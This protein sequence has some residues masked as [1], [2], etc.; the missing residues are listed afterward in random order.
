MS[1][2]LAAP[3]TDQ[4]SPAIVTD[5]LV[6][7]YGEIVALDGVSLTVP[8][9][10]ILG[11][12]GPSGAGKTTAVKILTG[13]LRPT[14][15]QA[16]VLGED[17]QRFS[18]RTRAR[19]GYMPQLFSLYP[20]LTAGENLDFVASLFGMLV[21]RRRRRVRSVLELVDLWDARKRRA[22]ELSGGMQRR[23]ELA[24]ALVHD[25]AVLFLDEPT[26]GLDPILRQTVWA[27]LHRLRD[28]G[29]T[30]VVT[31]QYIGESEECDAVALVSEGRLAAL[32]RP[33]DLRRSATGGDVL[34]IETAG[35]VDSALLV[36]LPMV[37]AVDQ[38]SG[39]R[40]FVT[41][42]DAGTAAPAIVGVIES[43]GGT[44]TSSREYRPSF[45]EVF[46]TL[47]D[48]HR[49]QLEEERA[50]S[51]NGSPASPSDTAAA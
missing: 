36:D 48:R 41:V 32:A 46:A 33:D 2:R 38:R 12:I 11:L 23:L 15:G 43:A 35:I 25:P 24:C 26:A 21:F 10:K 49:Q 16:R 37:R 9:G 22:A 19:I 31:T 3:P 50:N 5:A 28:L 45:D 6:R 29:R 13:G 1:N 17:P 39:R 4:S 14:S 34:E 20:D 40:F 44:V 18:R 51:A 47:V 42:D 8:A 7:R 27:E 30:I